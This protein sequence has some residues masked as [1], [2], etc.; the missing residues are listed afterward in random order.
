MTAGVA[1]VTRAD[2]SESLMGFGVITA[3][4]LASIDG[5]VA[6]CISVLADGKLWSQLALD[7]RVYLFHEHAIIA[8]KLHV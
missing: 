7:L 3:Q 4:M 1:H 6:L 2:Q 8:A 5:C